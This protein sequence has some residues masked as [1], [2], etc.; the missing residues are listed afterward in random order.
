MS[1]DRP[2]QTLADY[3]ALAISPA[4]IM[5]L[6][7]SLVFF[8]INVLYAGEYVERMQWILFFFVF[9]A[10]LIARMTML[11]DT[12]SRAALYGVPL[13]FLTWLGMQMFVEYPKESALKE[14]NWII[15]AG[16]IGLVW[17]C[18][19]RLTWDCTNI[20]EETD[21]N[22]EGLL[23]AAGLENEPSQTPEP[24][25]E[26][27]PQPKGWW[28]RWRRYR[29]ER[30]KKRTLGVWVVYF[31]LAA[32][33]LFGLGQALIAAE[34]VERRRT[35]F[36]LM[37]I[38]VGCGLGLLLTTCFLSLR[39]YL[40]QRRLQMPIAMTGVWLTVGGLLIAS[41]LV[42]GAVLPR[43]EA[44]YSMFSFSAAKS[45]KRGAS[46]HAMK[47][48]RPGEGEGRP[49]ADDPEGKKND[50]DSGGNK[51]Q[52][53]GQ[54]GEAVKQGKDGSDGR[55]E[56]SNQRGE[57]RGQNDGQ[58][59]NKGDPKSGRDRPA[60]KDKSKQAQGDNE[61]RNSSEGKESSERS[62]SG[63]SSKSSAS[64]LRD[65]VSRVGPVLKWIV[66]ALIGL[67][68][69]FFVLR[70]GL[71]FLANFSDWA[72]R[73]LDALRNFWANLFGGRR[74]TTEEEEQDEQEEETLHERP[75]AAFPNPF[76]G[77]RSGMALPEL[78]R[79][80]FAAVQAWAR[81]RGLGRQRGETPLEF[82]ERV[83][84]DVPALEKDLHRLSVL[85]ARAVYARGGLPSDSVEVLRQFWQR[86]E[87]VAEQPLSA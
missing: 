77:G 13:G 41:L 50:A 60:E 56:K 22:A 14:L 85:Y 63:S 32:L 59:Q 79:Y 24:E 66:F 30:E 53:K 72:R 47:G 71:R 64:S 35:S 26:K 9:G 68:V 7:A 69:L 48:D 4:L 23:Q 36:W 19:H 67:A 5:G 82:A 57:N 44:E 28:Q 86:L 49:G 29:E 62:D 3:V 20:D 2:N 75:F 18:A 38:Y 81:E 39:R 34:D 8:L 16:L 55:G 31:S 11:D 76:A 54:R 83:G 51:G 10:V 43:P 25:N 15:N 87:A 37:I 58:N 84:A 52:Q 45:P 12:S 33:P 74:Q 6:V 80:T 21:V 1:S 40:R 42:A 78:I 70:S 65:F 46:K 61:N 27:P 73:L 17:W